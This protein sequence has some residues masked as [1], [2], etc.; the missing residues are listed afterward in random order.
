MTNPVLVELTRG[1]LVES[2]HRGAI[3]I[4]DHDGRIR[5]ALGDIEAPHYPRSSLKPLQALPLVE[6]GAVDAFGL[7]DAH[8][9]LACAS[10]SGEPMHTERVAAWPARL[11]LQETELAVAAPTVAKEPTGTA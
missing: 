1:T 4:A 7:S 6:S 8:I 5:F 9:P 3:A 11:G 10:H 2:V